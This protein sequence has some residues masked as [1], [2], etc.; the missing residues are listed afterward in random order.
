MTARARDVAIGLLTG[1]LFGVG[2]VVSGMTKPAKVLGFL[3]VAGAWDASLALVMVGAIGVH[4]AAYQ[5]LR[6][7]GAPLFAPRF[8]LPSRTGLDAPLLAGAAIFGVGWGLGGFCPGPALTSAAAH[9]PGAV[10]FVAAMS[11]G[12]VLRHHLAPRTRSGDEAP[13]E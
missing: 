9:A 8:D 2:L 10:A 7:R 6:R 3:D 5:W 12:I 11:A 13:A 4:A 1:G